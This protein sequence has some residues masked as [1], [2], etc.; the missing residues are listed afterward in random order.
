M[1]GEIIVGVSV[2]FSLADE[3]R[4]AAGVD[5]I[6]A[7]VFIDDEDDMLGE[8]NDLGGCGQA[9]AD[10]GEKRRGT[11]DEEAVEAHLGFLLGGARV[12]SFAVVEPLR[13]D[14]TGQ[15]CLMRGR[16]A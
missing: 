5:L 9:D 12:R 3:P 15:K 13:A 6:E 4:H 16:G 7:R 11:A 8:R 1:I 10:E 2:E 14:S